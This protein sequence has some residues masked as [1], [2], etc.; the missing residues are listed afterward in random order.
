IP[1]LRRFAPRPMAR[2]RRGYKVPASNIRKVIQLMSRLSLLVK[3]AAFSHEIDPKTPLLWVLRDHLALTETKYGCGLGLCGACT[4][5]LD[6]AAIRSCLMPVG[7]I[8][9]RAITTI[10]GLSLDGSHPVQLGWI[11]E[12]V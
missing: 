11:V 4:V 8:G 5:H 9:T 3:C 2:D 12:A 1:A 10:E 7:S 6:G